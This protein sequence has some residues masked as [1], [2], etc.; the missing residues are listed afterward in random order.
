M[1]C[2]CYDEVNGKLGE[3]NTKIASY[4]SLDE[5]R[6]GRPWP[7]ETRQVET[8]RGKPKALGLFASYCPICGE[9]LRNK[10]PKGKGVKDDPVKQRS[11]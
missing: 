2:N 9:S 5:N 8:G 3:H 7:I 10:K 6:V 4:F 1:S 11:Q